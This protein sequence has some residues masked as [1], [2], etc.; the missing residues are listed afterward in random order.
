MS[1]KTLP[2]ALAPLTQIPSDP[3]L[4]G[5]LLCWLQGSGTAP[6]ATRTGTSQQTGSCAVGRQH[7]KHDPQLQSSSIRAGFH[8]QAS[9]N[10][11]QIKE[12]VPHLLLTC[13]LVSSSHSIFAEDRRFTWPELGKRPEDFPSLS[14]LYE[15][16]GQ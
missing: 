8:C 11:V 13:S 1:S 4:R 12:S 6:M 10:D 2:Q 14:A 16:H 15:I 7:C 3:V 5:I 9:I